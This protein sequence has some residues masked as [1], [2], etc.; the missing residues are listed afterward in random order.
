MTDEKNIFETMNETENT[1]TDDASVMEEIQKAS[2]ENAEPVQPVDS[3]FDL[4][5]L[6][7]TAYVKYNRV[8]LDDK[9]VTIK[10]AVI[11]L[12]H[13][14]SKWTE[15]KTNKD[16]HYKNYQFTVYYDTENND[17]ENYSGM[18]GFRN[19]DGSLGLPSIYTS[20]LT[21]QASKLFNKYKEF[22]IETKK[23][24]SDEFDET[25]GLKQFMAFLN[26]KP[27]ATIRVVDVTYDEK[28]YKKNMVHKFVA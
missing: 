2:N 15:G 12:P 17:R 21:T 24:T 19:D 10:K 4:N 25:Y 22:I 8:N 6:P 28:T 13:A 23:I 14:S 26:S 5:K 1:T 9:T 3:V 18:R 20:K 27:K 7:D 16:V 11:K